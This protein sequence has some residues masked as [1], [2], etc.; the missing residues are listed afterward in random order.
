MKKQLT[1]VQDDIN[2]LKGNKTPAK[3]K[4]KSFCVETLLMLF[5]AKCK[6]LLI[7]VFVNPDVLNDDKPLFYLKQLG[8]VLSCTNLAKE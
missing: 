7:D 1:Q 5:V 2:I 3:G 6:K 8:T 4:N